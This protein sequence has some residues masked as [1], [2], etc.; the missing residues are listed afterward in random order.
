MKDKYRFGLASQAGTICLGEDNSLRLLFVARDRLHEVQEKN[1][2]AE[3]ATAL[4]EGERA[5]GEFTDE[6]LDEAISFFRTANC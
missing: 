2:T 3:E 4:L 1:I 6:E 5:C